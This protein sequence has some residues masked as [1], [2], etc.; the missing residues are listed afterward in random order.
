MSQVEQAIADLQHAQV[1][2]RAAAAEKLATAGSDAAPASVALVRACADD[3]SVRTWAVAALE[4]L[5]PPPASTLAELKKLAEAPQPLVSYWA[6]TLIG[7]L[8][9]DAATAVPTLAGVVRT[10]ADLA[11]RERAAWALGQMTSISPDGVAALK[12]AAEA[13]EPRLARLAREA[14]EKT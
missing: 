9:D 12:T 14:L 8:G 7:R 6:V 2:V 3:E 4:D 11:T 1:E 13:N 5:G 10:A